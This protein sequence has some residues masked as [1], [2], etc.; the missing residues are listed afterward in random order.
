MFRETAGRRGEHSAVHNLKIRGD[1]RMKIHM[2][3]DVALKIDA[4][5]DFRQHRSFRAQFENRPFGDVMHGLSFGAGQFAVVRNLVYPGDEFTHLAFAADM[6]CPVFTGD[7]QPFGGKRGAEHD[8]AGILGDIDKTARA[9]AGCA[10]PCGIDVP[11]R[12]HL[13]GAHKGEVDPC[14]VVVEHLI[15]VANHRAQITADTEIHATRLLPAV[16]P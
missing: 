2:R 8:V 7:L 3:Q 11:V 13:A 15:L 14:A 4:G 9:G 1:R 6:Q 16:D 10:E 12:V 5:G